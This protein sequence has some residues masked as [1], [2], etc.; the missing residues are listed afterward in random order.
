MA[1]KDMHRLKRRLVESPFKPMK[2]R[3][4]A[5]LVYH[6]ITGTTR[7]TASGQEYEAALADTAIALCQ[8]ADVYYTNT[9][10]RLTLIPEDDLMHGRFE[11]AGD[12]F[13]ARSGQIYRN[14]ML[15]RSEVMD[16]VVILRKARETIDNAQAG[17]HSAVSGPFG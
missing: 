5:A 10:G 1:K 15:R 9:E 14:I 16:A 3:V 7:T 6:N 4:A 17:S 11:H 12:D 13:H 2:M 8:V